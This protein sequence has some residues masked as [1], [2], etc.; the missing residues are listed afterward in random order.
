MLAHH[1]YVLFFP[2]DLFLGADE[3]ADG[4]GVVLSTVDEHFVAY[5]YDG[6]L[7]GH[8]HMSVVQ[9]SATYE[10]APE[11]VAYLKYGAACQCGICGNDGHAVGYHVGV[12]CY[13]FFY[14][15]LFFFQ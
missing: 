13:L 2:N 3:G 1:W 8:A 6:V 4:F 10:V 12:G 5:V 14:L 9:D 11:E 15:L 7:V